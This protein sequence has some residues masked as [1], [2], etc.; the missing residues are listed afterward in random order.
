ME[1]KLF[2]PQNLRSSASIQSTEHFDE[3]LNRHV[4]PVQKIL[5]SHNSKR[6]EIGI[7]NFVCIEI[8]PTAINCNQENP[9]FS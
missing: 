4:R 3:T 9:D 6:V 8:E 1:M 5:R 2:V 7:P